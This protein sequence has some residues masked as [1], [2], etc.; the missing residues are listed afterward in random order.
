MK[1]AAFLRAINVAGHNRIKMDILRDMLSDHGM[2]EVS[3]YLQSGNVVFKS[4]NHKKE[5]LES[6]LERLLYK[7]LR[8]H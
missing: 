5:V 6:Q 2:T 1:Y 7:K 3:T 4:E 8:R